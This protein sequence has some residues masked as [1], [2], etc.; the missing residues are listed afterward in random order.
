MTHKNPMGTA[1][2]EFL[3]FSTDDLESLRERFN[4]LSFRHIANHKTKN[5]QLYRQGKA[6]F[7]I[8]AEPNSH[9]MNFAK[10]HGPATCAMGFKVADP[11]FAFKRAVDLGAKPFAMQVNPGESEI[12]AIYGVGDS[13]IYFIKS[14]DN[15]QIYDRDF[16]FIAQK[17]VP[18]VGVQHIDHVTHNL[19]RGNM[20]VW[21]DFYEKIFN[22][23]EIRFFDIKG[24]LTGLISRAITSPCGQITIPLNEAT[25][26]ASQIEEFIREFKGEGIQHIALAVDDIYDAV[27]TLKGQKVNFLDTPDTYYEMIADRVPW[28]KEDLAQLQKHK[29]LLDG[30]PD[31]AG[32]LLLQIFTENTIGPAFFEVIQRK[33]NSGFGEGNFKALFESIEL[34]QIRRGTL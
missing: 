24:K 4:A 16:D 9:A 8:N 18:G 34:D 1:G 21:A 31:P 3:E 15:G 32:G 5:V 13:L 19:K 25:E 23:R 22:F 26:E 28:H 27:E 6:N 30:A 2:F 11:Q 20:D 17:E 33:G 7:I 12:P 10:Q 29:I 14:D